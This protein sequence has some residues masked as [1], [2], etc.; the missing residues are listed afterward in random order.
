M[1]WLCIIVII[2]IATY[3]WMNS[4][5]IRKFCKYLHETD[6]G[7]NYILPT[8][9][10]NMDRSNLFILDVRKPE[11][12][13]AGHI[14]GAV[15]IFWLDLMKDEN[16]KKLPKDKEIIIVCYVGHTAS[17]LVVMLKL[18]GYNVKAL[19]FGMGVPPNKG[20]VAGW[21][22]LGYEVESN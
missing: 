11:D 21:L 4:C 8:D 15:N 2:I 17:Q 12:Y 19:K 14:P 5:N 6:D 10:H 13:K 3:A 18:L 16:I 20:Q 9:L 1:L 22:T 7:W